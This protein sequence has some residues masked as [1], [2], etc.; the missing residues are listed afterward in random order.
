VLAHPEVRAMARRLGCSV[1]QVVFRFA[2][3][4]GMLVLTGTTS[5]THMRDDLETS[6]LRLTPDEVRRIETLIG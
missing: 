4:V 1:S 2:F 5:A 3:E 6:D